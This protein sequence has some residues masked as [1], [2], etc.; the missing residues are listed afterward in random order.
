MLLKESVPEVRQNNYLFIHQVF[1]EFVRIT[2][3]TVDY[4]WNIC[5]KPFASCAMAWG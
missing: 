2:G 3:D 4:M 5:G 1:H